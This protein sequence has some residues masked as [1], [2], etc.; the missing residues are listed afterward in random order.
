MRTRHPII[1]NTRKLFWSKWGMNTVLKVDVWRSIN[2]KASQA[3]ILAPL[4]RLLD[5]VNHPLIHMICPVMMRNTYRLPMWQR[6][7]LEKVLVQHIYWPQPGSIS[8]PHLTHESTASELIQISISTTPTQWRVAVHLGYWILL[9]CGGNRRKRTQSTLISPVWRATYSVSYHM[10]SEWRPVFPL[11]EIL[12]A[13]DSQKTQVRPFAKTL[14]WGSLQEPIT[15]F[16]RA[17][18]QYRIRQ[19]LKTTRKWRMRRRI[20]NFTEWP[21]STTF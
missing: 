15:R 14:L 11:G 19:D 9:T 5:P 16:L 4:Q 20:G 6:Q 17:K 12:L 8:I 1:R 2:S 21:R 7:H 13:G 3:A 18:T 10:V